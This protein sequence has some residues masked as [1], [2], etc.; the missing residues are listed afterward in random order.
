MTEYIVVRDQGCVEAMLG[1]EL[2][3]EHFVRFDL[4]SGIGQKAIR[5]PNYPDSR[6]FELDHVKPWFC[7]GRTSPDNLV[8]RCL[9]CHA[10]KTQLERTCSDLVQHF[11]RSY[12]NVEGIVYAQAE[13][14]QPLSARDNI[15][16]SIHD[17]TV[18][19]LFLAQDLQVGTWRS[20]WRG[21]FLQRARRH[22]EKYYKTIAYLAKVPT[23]ELD[24]VSAL[25]H[26][27]QILPTAPDRS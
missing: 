15:A 8:V 17:Q 12:S 24:S 16:L 26:R 23:Q 19:S 11:F 13:R 9:T 22:F 7:G 3:H 18:E 5:G 10:N 20:E 2:H 1:S 25:V 21:H 6:H 27:P 14:A 4:I